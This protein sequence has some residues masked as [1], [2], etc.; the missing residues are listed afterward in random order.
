MSKVEEYGLMFMTGLMTTLLGLRIYD[1]IEET[2]NDDAG[3]ISQ[4]RLLRVPPEDF[5]SLEDLSSLLKSQTINMKKRYNATANA[6]ALKIIVDRALSG[7][8][9]RYILDA[10]QSDNESRKLKA[11]VVVKHLSQ[12]G[13]LYLMVL[14]FTDR[15]KTILVN[16]KTLKILVKALKSDMPEELQKTAVASIYQLILENDN[17][18]AKAASYGLI[19][20]LCSF[21][22]NRP[23]RYSDLKYWSILVLHQLC[24]TDKLFEQL[25]D[26]KVIFILA[27]MLKL[28][29]GTPSMQKLCLHGIVRLLGSFSDQF[30]EK[31]LQDLAKMKLI[32]LT[33]SC[34]R[35]NDSDLVSWSIFLIH[36][37]VTR[38]VQVEEI[39]KIRGL[40]K[41]YQPYIRITDTIL[42]R[43][44]LRTLKCLCDENVSFYRE[45]I[46]GKIIPKVIKCLKSNDEQTQYWSLALLHNVVY[47]MGSHKQL[48]K[49]GLMDALLS[50]PSNTALIHIQLYIIEIYG[51]L[52]ADPENI[53]FLES[54]NLAEKLMQY[55]DSTDS[56]IQ[57][58]AISV[59]IN[60]AAVSESI[61]SSIVQHDGIHILTALFLHHGNG[62]AIRIL[63]C[64]AVLSLIYI[65]PELRF[66]TLVYSIRPGF[67]LL[68]A[69][70]EQ[71]IKSLTGTTSPTSSNE[72]SSGSP[73][74]T[75]QKP[76]SPT[77]AS[78]VSSSIMSSTVTELMLTPIENKFS[79]VKSSI[80]QPLSTLDHCNRLQVTINCLEVLMNSGL[81]FDSKVGREQSFESYMDD[82]MDDI[83]AALMNCLVFKL[84]DNDK[85]DFSDLSNAKSEIA[86]YGLRCLLTLFRVGM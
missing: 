17:R 8:H 43:V 46:R 19:E 65:D 80:E 32:S 15:N 86:Y 10:V 84:I 77:D 56:E 83:S 5:I 70:V 79:D 59:L 45:L 12:N 68:I 78:I 22:N 24:V 76:E 27:D 39:C 58:S 44:I 35:N 73:Q 33:S 81:L 4:D 37:F 57:Q 21:L 38:K 1:Y 30:A 14:N 29:F 49:L 55:I 3:G 13:I 11:L 66:E 82:L 47:Q 69:Q 60:I 25:F 52:C 72:K 50:M 34:L 54:T 63:A 2:H 20:V 71:A 85:K 53:K 6:S 28:T 51:V 31:V 41:I 64:K 62:D 48:L 75:K 16:M 42:P 36:E 74:S 7:K 18:K 67:Q 9:L 26:N 23:A 61:T 40:V